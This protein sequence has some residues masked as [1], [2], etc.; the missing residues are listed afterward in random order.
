MVEKS[1]GWSRILHQ[2]MIISG[3]GW[4]TRED[5]MTIKYI[6]QVEDL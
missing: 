1:T 4:Y 2:D 6:T 3:E 5:V